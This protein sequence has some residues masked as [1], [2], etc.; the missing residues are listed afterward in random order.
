[1]STGRCGRGPGAWTRLPIAQLRYDASAG[2]WTLYWADRNRR[3][4]RYDHLAPTLQLDELL[5]EI[6]QDPLSLFWG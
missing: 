3:W 2:T 6:D 1:M 5:K 4:H